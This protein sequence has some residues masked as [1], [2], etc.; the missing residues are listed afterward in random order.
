[1]LW[2]AAQDYSNRKRIQRKTE[3]EEKEEKEIRDCLEA[4]LPA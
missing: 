4:S 2:N 3:Y 1:M